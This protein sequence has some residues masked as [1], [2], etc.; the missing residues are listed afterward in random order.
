M[1]DDRGHRIRPTPAHIGKSGEVA[2]G[3]KVV[4]IL[5]KEGWLSFGGK[6]QY[7]FAADWEMREIQDLGIQARLTIGDDRDEIGRIHHL[8]DCLV[9]AQK[10]LVGKARIETVGIQK[11][12]RSSPMAGPYL[13]LL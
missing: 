13:V 8:S 2:C 4:E 10:L 12:E 1:F 9:T 11:Q 3:G 5:E 7:P 6:D